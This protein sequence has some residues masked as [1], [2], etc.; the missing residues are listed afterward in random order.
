M[1]DLTLIAVDEDDGRGFLEAVDGETAEQAA[2]RFRRR[3]PRD[4]DLAFR[5]PISASGPRWWTAPDADGHQQAAGGGGVLRCWDIDLTAADS[6]HVDSRFVFAADQIYRH[7]G[8]DVAEMP[9]CGFA[10]DA[11]QLDADELDTYTCPVC[12]GSVAAV[13]G[14][15]GQVRLAEIRHSD[16]RPSI[17]CVG[18]GTRLHAGEGLFV[19]VADMHRSGRS[20]GSMV[21]CGGCLALALQPKAVTAAVKAA[22]QP[23]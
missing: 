12:D 3:A 13:F 2:G 20:T 10:F 11:D 21:I 6:I 23:S 16:D 4:L 1:P 9:C 8:V 19:G 18:C 14:D 22:A 7:R 17:A 15:T 5:G